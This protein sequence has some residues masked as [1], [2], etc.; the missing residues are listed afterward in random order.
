MVYYIY[1]I[2]RK[3]RL[4]SK[5]SARYNKYKAATTVVEFIT[6]LEVKR[7]ISNL[8]CSAGI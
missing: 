7:L 3:Y 5:S 6:V 1:G 4:D 8:T 2:F